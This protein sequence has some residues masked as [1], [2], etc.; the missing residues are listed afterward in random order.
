MATAIIGGAGYIGAH[1]VSLLRDRDEKV[2]IVDDFSTGLAER[3]QGADFLHLDICD[4]AAP[5]VLSEFFRTHG[6]NSVM[7][8][9]GKKQVFESLKKPIWYYE[10]NVSGTAN[11]LHA[12]QLA[13]VKTFVF[14]SSA[15]VYG[16]S[17]VDEVRENDKTSPINPYGE[18]KLIGEWLVKNVSKACG[19]RTVNLRYFNVVGAKSA[20]LADRG[21][22][23]LVPIALQQAIDGRALEVF[24]DDYDTYDGTC[25]R[26]YIHVEDLADAHVAARDFIAAQ[27]EGESRTYNVGTGQGSSVKQIVDLVRSVTARPLPVE[28]TPRRPGDPPA[29]TANVDLIREDLDWKAQWTVHEAIES[30]WNAAL[31]WKKTGN[32][33]KEY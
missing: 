18:T 4:H 28:V 2:V 6:V 17:E 5:S 23:N 8:F 10:Q 14:S 22:F 32:D 1:V 19:I 25:V 27:P 29:I 3:L 31:E 7:H 15:A 21:Q 9:A 20:T 12:A 33:L 24:G 11:V 30:A 26:D 16:I 13:G